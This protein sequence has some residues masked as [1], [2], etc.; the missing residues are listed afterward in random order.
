[1]RSSLTDSETVILSMQVFIQQA[2]HLV[3]VGLLG[4]DDLPSMQQLP[5]A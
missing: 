3:L 1:M 5:E 2:L 4:V